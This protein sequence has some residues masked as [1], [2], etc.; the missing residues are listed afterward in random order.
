MFNLTKFFKAKEKH[1]FHLVDS[2]LLPVVTGFS[3][4]LIALSFVFYWHP[5][6]IS[7]VAKF[8]GLLIQIAFFLFISVLFSWFTTV[9]RES[10]EGHHTKM[11]RT[12]LRYGMAL[13]IVSEVMFFFAFFWGFFH[14][15]LSPSIAIGCVWP[16]KSIQPLDI[17]G[18]PLVNTLLLLTSGLTITL[19]HHAILKASTF[20][21]HKAFAKHLFVTILL[22]ITFL[23]CQGI[24]YKYGV[25]F[26]WK[27]NVYGSSFFITTG[28]HGFHVT[29]GTIFLL[30]C[31]VREIFTINPLLSTYAAKPVFIEIIVGTI[32]M[33]THIPRSTLFEKIENI[34]LYLSRFAFTKE[35]HFG[36]EAAA[37]YWHFVDVVW[38]FL[39]ITVYWWGS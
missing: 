28:F 29:V 20:S 35:Q 22:G 12:G 16:P 33:I 21:E 9:V 38:L 6:S 10:G 23:I 24:E 36:F 4:M 32:S 37:W 14:F 26:K 31:F 1:T 7:S 18:L 17:W 11:V 3:A 15:S 39:F 30:F 27:E 2:S 25:T 5:S 13:F 8:D 34:Q 19:A